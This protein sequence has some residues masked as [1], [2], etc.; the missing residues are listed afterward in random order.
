MSDIK[1]DWLIELKSGDSERLISVEPSKTD[2]EVI[3]Q[4]ESGDKIFKKEDVKDIKPVT[5]VSF[6]I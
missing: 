1:Y 2:T 3:F 4:T 6:L 5:F